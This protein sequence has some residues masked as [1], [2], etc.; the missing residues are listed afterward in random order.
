MKKI[1]EILPIV[2][3]LLIIILIGEVFILYLKVLDL[4]KSTTKSMVCVPLVK[5]DIRGDHYLLECLD[6]EEYYKRHKEVV[7][8]II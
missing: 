1:N 7:D 4:K 8:P 6:K 3:L 5:E 2:A